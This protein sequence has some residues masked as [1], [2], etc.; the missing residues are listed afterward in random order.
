MPALRAAEIAAACGGAVLRGDPGVVATSFSIDTR[1]LA[2]GAAFFALRGE[3]SDG[4]VFLHEAV[5]AG[6]MVVVV[7][8]E[9]PSDLAAGVAVVRTEETA[10]ALVRCGAAA[11]RKIVSA[12]VVAITGSSGKTTTKELLGAGLAATKRVHKTRANLNN[13]LGV[14]LTLLACPEDAEVVVLELAMRGAGQIAELTTISDPDVGLVTNVRPVHLEFFRTLDDIAAAK[15]E[16]FAVL[17]DDAVA[18]VNVDD[19]HV[20]I[21]S[22]R[23]SGRRVTYGRHGSA[24]LVL[25]SVEDRFTPG[26]SFSFRHEGKVR[27]LDLK[28]AG[29]HAAVNALAALAVVV[30]VGADLDRAADALRG[31]EP[32]PGRGR[33]LTLAHGVVVVDESYNSNPA[34]L[35][36]VLRTVGASA[37]AGRK[38]LVLGDMLELGPE[39]TTYHREAGRQAASAGVQVLMG[40]G[41]LA[42]AS[43]EAG[44]KAGVPE[45]RHEPDA[46]VAA[47]ELPRL[48]RPGDL[49]VVKGS[50]GV[51]LEQ[52]VNALV[53]ALR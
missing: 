43:V 41:P 37:P 23:H 1:T 7:Q 47:R 34:A 46:G 27:R 6:A 39:E 35:S 14:P 10:K 31:V 28:L 20:R 45:V 53:E 26:A 21:Q 18:V 48:V 2:P 42:R 32:G 52:V 16:L 51:H 4:H 11:R 44:R 19:E 25:E 24:D 5:R 50:R 36:S 38:V 33:V 49:V 9:P 13:E 3:R 22:A 30:A 40:V 29:S 17:R 15:G 12:Q 8:Q